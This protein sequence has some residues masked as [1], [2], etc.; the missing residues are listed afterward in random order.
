MCQLCIGLGVRVPC[1]PYIAVDIQL[2][3]PSGW[4]GTKRGP[5]LLWQCHGVADAV[6]R[7]LVLFVWCLSRLQPKDPLR[8]GLRS[9]YIV[10]AIHVLIVSRCVGPALLRSCKHCEVELKRFQA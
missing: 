2:E 4:A 1:T 10:L 5:M 6:Q 8:L 9:I 3:G 7:Y